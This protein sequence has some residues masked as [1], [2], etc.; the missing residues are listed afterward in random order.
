M[1]RFVAEVR[2]L[3]ERETES[4]GMKLEIDAQYEGAARFDENKLKRVI[5]NLARNACQ[6]MEPGGTVR[7]RVG[8]D[9]RN[10]LLECADDGPGIPREM[11]GRLFESFSTHGKAEGTGLGL[12]MA[13]K[14][15]DAHCGT[16]TCRSSPGVGATFTITLPL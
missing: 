12:A 7:L 8:C 15:V 14:I 6:A 3:L 11:E 1:H 5:F 10:L 2:E 9:E 16:L 13:R 4:F